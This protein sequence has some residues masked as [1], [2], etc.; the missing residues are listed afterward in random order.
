MIPIP[1]FVAFVA[2]PRFEVTNLT[3]KTIAVRSASVSLR[4]PPKVRKSFVPVPDPRRGR[5]YTVVIADDRGRPIGKLQ[6][7]GQLLL[8]APNRPV[9]V[10]VA[11]GEA[12]VKIGSRRQRILLLPR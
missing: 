4:V 8:A 3:S 12:R 2:G 6:F 11:D 10:D 1:L 7:A 9:R 5:S